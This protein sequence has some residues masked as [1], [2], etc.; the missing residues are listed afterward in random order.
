MGIVLGVVVR[1]GLNK[2]GTLGR[3]RTFKFIYD[4]KS[5]GTDR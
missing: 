1:D 5:S 4:E 2:V 3:Y